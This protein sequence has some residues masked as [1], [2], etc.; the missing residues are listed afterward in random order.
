MKDIIIGLIIG[1]AVIAASL[2]A[3]NQSLCFF[4]AS[5]GDDKLAEI[6]RLN[7]E[8][9]R[10]SADSL[11]LTSELQSSNRRETELLGQLE[12]V[13]QAG[14]QLTENLQQTAQKLGQLITDNTLK[15]D[16]KLEGIKHGIFDIADI[17][18]CYNHVAERCPKPGQ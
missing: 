13:Q 15:T 4:N 18:D 3:I 14:Q 5:C 8:I 1:F 11:R 12:S 2:G 7:A 17:L 9:T 6:E 16:Q 10:L